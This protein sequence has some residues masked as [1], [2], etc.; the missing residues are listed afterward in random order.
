MNF[1]GDICDPRP[2]NTKNKLS[3]FGKIKFYLIRS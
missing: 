3:G 2:K 1:N